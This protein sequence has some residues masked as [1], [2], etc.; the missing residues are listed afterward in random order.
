MQRIRQGVIWIF[1]FANFQVF[2]QQLRKQYDL[3]SDWLSVLHES[4]S[5]AFQ[6]FEK[7]SYQP[8]RWL[9][10]Q[11]PHNWDT[12]AG[13]RRLL[14]GNTHGYAWYRKSFR[15]KKEAGDKRYFLYFE[16]VGSYA[17]IWVNGKKIGFHAGGRTTFTIDISDVILFDQDNLLAVRADHP[18]GI[19]DLP[20]VCGGCSE[21]RGFS[22]G[23]QPLGIFRP[24]H[25]YVTDALRIEPFGV[26]I[27]NDTS[28]T[29][30]QAKLFLN[31]TVK[32]Y[33]TKDKKAVII[34]Q[35]RAKDGRVVAEDHQQ[36]TITGGSTVEIQQQIGLKNFVHLWSPQDPYLYTIHSQIRID[37]QVVDDLVT[38][39]GIRWISWPINRKGD[40][41]RFFI[42]G[43]PFFINGI[44]EYE[45]M[46][47]GSHAFSD[48]QIK[49]RV[50]QIRAA[51]F[52]AF[53][54]AHQP[55][56]L[57]YQ[58]HWDRL[59]I[60][61]WT[62]LAAHIW[63]EN[64]SFKANFKKLLSEWVIERR[65][66]PSVVLWG[67]ENES[68]L[69]E[70]FARECTELI[71]SLDPTA[72]SQRK[73]T[74][75]NGGSGT[76]WDVPQNW[77][78]TYGGDP[79]LYDQ[80]L[81]KQILVGEYGA[82]R[83]IDFHA[84]KPFTKASANT[85]DRMR[86]LMETKIRLAEKVKD[87][88]AG[89]FFWLFNSHDNPGR[90]QGGE[91]LRELDR[92]GPVNYKGLLTPW[93]EP[94]DAY[95]MFRANYAD[96]KTAPMVYI[97]SHTW[98]NRWESPGIK[99]EIIVYS[100]CDEVELFNDVDGSSIGRKKNGGIGRPFI[101]NKV[102]VRF[103]VLHAKGYVNGRN[104]AED[105]VVLQGLPKAPSFGK[106]YSNDEQV[107]AKK[108][109]EYIYRVNCGG[110]RYV[111]GEGHVWEAD[112]ERTANDT[113][114]SS[115]WT[116]NFKLPA[117]F[118][119]QR[120]TFD[121][122]K[123]TREW[124][125]LQTFRYG[126]DQLNFQFP[127][128]DG[129][130]LIELYFIEPWF[131]TGGGMDCKGWRLFDVAINGD[132]VDKNIDIWR[133]A[134]HDAVLKKTYT[135]TAKDGRIVV[136]FPK[137]AS[138]QAVISAIA[139][140][141]K[142]KVKA[143]PPSPLIIQ[144][145]RFGDEKMNLQAATWL[146]IGDAVF[147]G[148]S[149][150]FTTIPPNL[151]GATWLRF[152]ADLISEQK[153]LSFS[154]SEAADVFI[155]I[156]EDSLRAYNSLSGYEDTQTE[157]ASAGNDRSVWKIYRKRFNKNSL[158][159]LS[160]GQNYLPLAPVMVV[161]ASKLQSAHDL[162]TSISYK[163]A[164]AAI[165]SGITSFQYL[166]KEALQLPSKGPAQIEWTIKTGVADTYS[167]TLR[168]A[169]SGEEPVEGRLTLRNLDG[170]ILHEEMVSFTSSR[171]GKWSYLYSNTATMINAGQYIVELSLSD[172]KALIIS[173]L[174]VQ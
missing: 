113:W 86:E 24:V 148:K 120:R 58:Q 10:V 125:L 55:H 37:D 67:L 72:S 81:K 36:Q 168:Y 166:K 160:F 31:T 52:N 117:N 70:E 29:S 159:K 23:S 1:I 121:P 140:A 22:E 90:V 110:P 20:W 50:N 43:T 122:I 150:Y 149:D 75:C 51:G 65:N 69:P 38:P 54:D 108:G 60:L 152:P 49:A 119:S 147:S 5:M 163:P 64:E 157:I 77:T 35:V 99:N 25:L 109:Y 124:P 11:V 26:H 96:A 118:A 91:G 141:G 78:G 62:Q 47:G 132:I 111:D 82:W 151:F 33:D 134:G 98:P 136:S 142:K 174:D 40:D 41:K 32:N 167:M 115:S 63:F 100:N 3:S 27:W 104:V 106:L 146:D 21:E 14:H 164:T 46:L 59:G 131:G 137:V 97:V 57:R 130:Y 105:R 53:R 85:E 102:P 8:E 92:I 39:Y 135:A 34:Q 116:A 87:S 165:S 127:I 138:G 93:D 169:Y 139:I 48:A 153:K 94:T 17:T 172:A 95:Y 126:K 18:A 145:A 56:N 6:G 74:T 129:E 13:Y 9:S 83:S 156:P 101:W 155:L 68:T 66:S 161:P 103:N 88:V 173:N 4:D 12:Y 128:P 170:R 45:H 2:A 162:K 79:M 7:Q 143:A 123:G 171:I 144:Q 84:E 42:N 112:R 71:R 73:V 19:R 89:H 154:V 15:I 133:E 44:A 80:D 16:G 76:D 28:V 114:G 30:K 61:S 158:V 107:E